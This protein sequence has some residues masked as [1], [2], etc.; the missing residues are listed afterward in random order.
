M[1][2][3]L[4]MYLKVDWT[5]KVYVT[6]GLIFYVDYLEWIPL[7]HLLDLVITQVTF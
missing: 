2:L 5:T 4:K 3:L 6:L 7:F 1:L